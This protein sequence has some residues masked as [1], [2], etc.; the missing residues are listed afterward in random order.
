MVH[1]RTFV[2]TCVSVVERSSC[3]TLLHG[4]AVTVLALALSTLRWCCCCCGWKW[5]SA[6][7][8]DLCWPP[9]VNTCT[10]D[11]AGL[12]WPF[13]IELLAHRQHTHTT[14]TACN[15]KYDTEPLYWFK[16]WQTARLIY[17]TKPRT[18]S[19]K[20]KTKNKNWYRSEKAAMVKSLYSHEGTNCC[21]NFFTALLQNSQS[22]SVAE[23]TTVHIL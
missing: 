3:D 12:E 10:V 17:C 22:M 1:D 7:V 15:I 20:E 11:A 4:L 13:T 19:I 23:T 2:K 9:A 5:C 6:P 14:L 8:L 16:S 18:K 21:M